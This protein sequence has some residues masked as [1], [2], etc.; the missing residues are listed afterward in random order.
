MLISFF[1]ISL[2]P[3]CALARK[4]LKDLIGN[5]YDSSVIEV[6]ILRQPSKARKNRIR[7]VPALKYGDDLISGG[8]LS[9][10]SIRQFLQKNNLLP[11]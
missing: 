3:R 1:H 4:H 11:S 9:R 7:M 6:N 2:C 10:A 5:S 8:L